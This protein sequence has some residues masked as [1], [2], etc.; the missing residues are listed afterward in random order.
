MDLLASLLPTIII[1]WIPSHVD[2]PGNEA[3]DAA[4]K[5]ATATSEEENRPVSLKSAINTIKHI[6]KDP[7]I[8]HERTK[9]I[10]S[11]VNRRLDEAQVH[12]KEDEILLSRLRSGHHPW[13]RAYANRMNPDIDPLCPSCREEAQTLQHWLIVCPAIEL[14]RQRVFGPFEGQLEWLATHPK[15]TIAFARR[16]LVPLDV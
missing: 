13:L 3:A 15:M 14:C 4:A 6:I 7:D 8:S 16:T 9:E 5:E 11:K 10:Y 12:S 1:Q 2:I